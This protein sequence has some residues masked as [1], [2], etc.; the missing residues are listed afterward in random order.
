VAAGSEVGLTT[1][2]C[3]ES[4]GLYGE[5]WSGMMLDRKAER[6]VWRVTNSSFSLTNN[7]HRCKRFVSGCLQDSEKIGNE[8]DKK[9]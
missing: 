8:E 7:V 4:P 3:M 2:W 1:K 6:Q 5:S 9:L